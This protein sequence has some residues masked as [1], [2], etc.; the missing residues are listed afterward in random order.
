MQH[1]TA[2]LKFHQ[3]SNRLYDPN[4]IHVEKNVLLACPGDNLCAINNGG[5]SDICMVAAGGEVEC[6]C[7]DF[8]GKR[9]GNG[10]KMCVPWPNDCSDDQFVCRN[11]NCINPHWLCDLD[12][13]C[14]DGT[15][16]DPTV[17]GEYRMSAWRQ[18]GLTGYSFNYIVRPFCLQADEKG[19][20]HFAL[21]SHSSF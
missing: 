18:K 11:G 9:I 13:D 5:C 6:H 2:R 19:S 12:D 21:P 14:K 10:G 16:E 8:S 3:C 4:L 1:R 15:D 20:L 7:P 17:C